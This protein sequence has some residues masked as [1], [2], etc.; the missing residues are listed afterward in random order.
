MIQWVSP[1]GSFEHSLIV[2]TF[3]QAFPYATLW[4]GGDLLIG[5]PEPL[6]LSRSTLESRLTD[7]RARPALAEVGFNRAQDVLAQFRAD[8]AA[9]RAYAGEG[10]VLTDDHPLLE[11]FLALDAPAEPANLGG[12]HGQ[13]IVQD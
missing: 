10:P 9:L 6:V 7:A 12:L 8:S 3:L 2:R 4:L 1:G 5:S 13:P 11:Y